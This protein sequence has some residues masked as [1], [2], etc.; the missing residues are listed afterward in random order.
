[1]LE[2]L[3]ASLSPD[4]L[5]NALASLAPV[6]IEANRGYGPSP[7]HRLDV[8]RPRRAGP[9]PMAVFFYGGGW[10]EGDR[11]IYRFVGAALASAGVV[12]VIPDYRVY[13]EVRFPGFVEDGAAAVLWAYQHAARFG[14]DP[15]RLV[16]IG[17]SAG[18]HIAAMLA[19]DPQWLRA[20][21]LPAKVVRGL[22][23]L[24]GPYDFH[25]DT[26]TRRIIFGLE[27]DRAPT[28]PISFARPDAP[29]A[30]LVSGRGD[31]VVDPGNA[32]RLAQRL[33]D[34]G[35]TAEVKFYPHASH[36]SLIGAFSP[37]LRFVAPV[38]RDTVDFIARTATAQPAYERA[39]A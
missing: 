6:D 19:L 9:H 20:E 39:T 10:E 14:A 15:D 7:R 25:P 27:R 21:K 5:L 34:V 4:R 3:A 22:V 18:A 35:A 13:P 17:H 38:F 26:P 12:T 8:Y 36:E 33:R 31:R 30:L 29:P 16:L 24:A 32:T 1:V 28:Q 11:A 37:A 23:G 2:R